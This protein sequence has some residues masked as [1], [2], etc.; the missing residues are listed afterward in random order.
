[1]RTTS[2][3][4]PD[5]EMTDLVLTTGDRWDEASNRSIDNG[6]HPEA[7]TFARRRAVAYIASAFRLAVRSG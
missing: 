1:V 6:C 5:G 3:R 2:C 4:G 7:E